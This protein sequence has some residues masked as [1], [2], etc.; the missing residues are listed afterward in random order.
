MVNLFL[1]PRKNLYKHFVRAFVLTAGISCWGVTGVLAG[2]PQ[3]EKSSIVGLRRTSIRSIVPPPPS[4][5]ELYMPDTTLKGLRRIHLDVSGTVRFL[6][7]YRNM[8]IAYNDL[9]TSQKNFS[10]TEYQTANAGTSAAGGVPMLELY[11]RS[12]ISSAFSFN[13]GYSFSHAFNGLNPP[14]GSGPTLKVVNNLWFDGN[15]TARTVN[16]HLTAGTILWTSMSR[17][18][19]GQPGNYRD[20]YFYRLPWDWYRKSF[21]RWDEYYSFNSNIGSQGN[22]RSALSGFVGTADFYR[23]GITVTGIFGRTNTSVIYGN[24]TTNFPS[25]VSGIKAEKSIFTRRIAGRV[26]FNIYARN[27]YTDRSQDIKDNNQV[28][29]LDGK[30]RYK[31]IL[32]SGE[33]GMGAIN[34]PYTLSKVKTGFGGY[35]RA[36]FDKRVSSIPFNVELYNIN[37]NLVS[38]DGSVL[39]SNTQ[40][41][42]GGF[43]NSYIYDMFM[44]VNVA[45]EVGILANNRR[46]LFLNGE[47]NIK[48]LKILLGMGISQEIE[49]LHDTI[50][51]QHRVNS[52]PRSRFHPWFQAAG[53][54][55]RIKSNFLRTF[56]TITITDV[57]KNYKKGFNNLELLMKYKVTFLGRE[58][59][60]LY[61]NTFQSVQ[62]R[63][64]PVP[65]FT[66]VNSVFIRQ[67]F[68]DLTIAYKL[69]QKVS[70][71]AYGG[72][73]KLWGSMRT[74]LA[75]PDGTEIKNGI[76][77]P[78]SNANGL[79]IDQTGWGLGVGIDYDF[80]PTAGIHVRQ[81]WM[82]Q[83]DKNFKF[84]AFK[85]T[86]TNVELKLFF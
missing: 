35:L 60:F 66:A 44:F 28:Y 33:F 36:D 53:P 59:V 39:N 8:P 56:E 70:L 20:N 52:I 74:N 12:K 3:S 19:M 11:L 84:D 79:P 68:T 40:V 31:K 25:Y 5:T 63:L 72:L 7:I 48:K 45:Q 64:S 78:T 13:V 61:F 27:A 18:T 23:V 76:G 1:K 24:S 49:N 46:G 50:T 29:T 15:I 42:G 43:P 58:M 69:S 86:E 85:G 75:N 17:F 80:S 2:D 55:S 4:G 81:T 9:Q 67:Y 34:N 21:D 38:F 83:K 16:L 47:A 57:N 65:I 6:T 71:S 22:G 32:F 14:Q 62:D 37:N 77:K 30:I 51:I 26:G 10:F 54:Y 82:S 41:S 73:E